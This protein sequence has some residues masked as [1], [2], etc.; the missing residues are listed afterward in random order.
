MIR[1]ITILL[2]ISQLARAEDPARLNVLFIAVDDLKPNLGCYGDTLALTPHMDAI[3]AKGTIFSANYCQQA[4]CAP[5][6]ASLLTGRYPDQL[7]V[8]DLETQIRDLNPDIVS[9]PQYMIGM[10]YE[11]AATGKVF[12]Y[13]SVDDTGDGP[14]WSIP[15]RGSW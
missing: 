5:S 15:Y 9:L 8:W 10:G 1:I 13:R 14:S 7:R 3:A 2:L 11:T 12:D 4:V 6:R